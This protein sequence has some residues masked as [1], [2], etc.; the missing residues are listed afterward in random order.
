MDLSYK[1]VFAG[2]RP[3]ATMLTFLGM[4]PLVH[5]PQIN[6]RLRFP[7]LC[8]PITFYT[9]IPIAGI[10]AAASMAVYFYGINLNNDNEKNVTI[11]FFCVSSTCG[12]ILVLTSAIT[13]PEFKEYFKKWELIDKMMSL[14]S[15][16]YVLRRF[17]R[18]L[19]AICLGHQIFGLT[20]A[21]T[22]L[23]YMNVST[24]NVSS[25]KLIVLAIVFWSVYNFGSYIMPDMNFVYFT[26]TLQIR[27]NT[28]RDRIKAIVEQL[29]FEKQLDGLDHEISKLR[30]IYSHLM[31]MILV[32]SNVL[33]PTIL[34]VTISNGM[35]VS[36]TVY[37]LVKQAESQN[38]PWLVLK[39][40]F[41]ILA[42]VKFALL[43]FSATT[44]LKAADEVGFII[45]K[46]TTVKTSEDVIFEL[47]MFLLEIT[48]NKAEFTASGY[49]SLSLGFL[50]T[51][52]FR[53]CFLFNI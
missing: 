25:S 5:D 21:A 26:K 46:A 30:I 34:F 41:G 10:V 28:V 1:E 8:S 51:V 3:M 24:K 36:L 49:F 13:A 31:D 32:T 6:L 29:L 53:I 16:D 15:T 37:G 7:G 19:T 47:E 43:C 18:R 22:I 35:H 12:C 33:A 4:Y 38:F 17:G 52:S 27:F 45:K 9:L 42:F 39:T 14:N 2:F 44:V 20:A 48:K 11:S 40:T 23:I 50:S